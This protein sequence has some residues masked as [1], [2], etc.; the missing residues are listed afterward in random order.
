MVCTSL[1][2]LAVGEYSFS[3]TRFP[4]GFSVFADGGRQENCYDD[5]HALERFVSP[6]RISHKLV[7]D[8]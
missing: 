8:V 7:K 3:P 2:F 1:G 5:V 4:F 6:W